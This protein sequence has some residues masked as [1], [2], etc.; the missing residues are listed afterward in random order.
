MKNQLISVNGFFCDLL[1]R[2]LLWLLLKPFVV[3][4]ISLIYYITV[5]K[6]FR[7]SN[8][9]DLDSLR[10]ASEYFGSSST[11]T[12]KESTDEMNILLESSPYYFIIA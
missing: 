6:W 2:I 5:G 7:N 11:S 1:S 3:S 12:W 10:C 8:V 4:I 9:D